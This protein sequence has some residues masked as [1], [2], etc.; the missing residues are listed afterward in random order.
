MAERRVDLAIAGESATVALDSAEAAPGAS[1]S[2]VTPSTVDPILR[3]L[4]VRLGKRVGAFR[5]AT[6]SG[7][8]ARG[9]VFILSG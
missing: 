5:P 3:Q 2:K 7:A 1:D 9:D 6:T 8:A 4:S